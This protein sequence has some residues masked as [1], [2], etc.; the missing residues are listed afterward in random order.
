MKMVIPPINGVLNGDMQIPEREVTALIG[1]SEPEQVID[2]AG[3]VENLDFTDS[4][5][6]AID[7]LADK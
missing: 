1:P 3:V 5:L 4:E 7:A 6:D 2:C